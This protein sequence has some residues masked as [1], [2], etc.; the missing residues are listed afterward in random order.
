MNELLQ[1]YQIAFGSGVYNGEVELKG[2]TFRY[3]SG[4]SLIQ[5]PMGGHVLLAKLTD[6]TNRL[7]GSSY[8]PRDVGILGLFV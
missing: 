3:A 1:P 4:T 5:F 2:N 6:Q 8:E 7:L